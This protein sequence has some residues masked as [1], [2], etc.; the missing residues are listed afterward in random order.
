MGA[1]VSLSLSRDGAHGEGICSSFFSSI[2]DPFPRDHGFYVGSVPFSRE[3][4]YYGAG[5]SLSFPQEGVHGNLAS[6]EA[7]PVAWRGVF[8]SPGGGIGGR[9]V[10]FVLANA[11]LV[12][13]LQH[14][15]LLALGNL[16]VDYSHAKPTAAYGS[17]GQQ[18]TESESGS[19]D[20]LDG[21]Y[22]GL[23][24]G[25]NNIMVP[26]S[27]NPELVTAGYGSRVPDPAGGVGKCNGGG[28]YKA[29]AS[30]TARMDGGAMGLYSDRGYPGK[31][32]RRGLSLEWGS[33]NAYVTP[34]ADA[35]GSAFHG[36]F[37]FWIYRRRRWLKQISHS[38]DIGTG[39]GGS[40]SYAIVGGSG[41]HS[42][43]HGSGDSFHLGIASQS[44]VR[45]D[46]SSAS[47]I[48]TSMWIPFQMGHKFHTVGGDCADSGKRGHGGEDYAARF[49][50]SWFCCAW[51]L[52]EDGQVAY[53]WLTGRSYM[54]LGLLTVG[55][56]MY[57]M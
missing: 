31:I 16:L 1:G 22:G 46:L 29:S 4:V 47:V 27:G 49:F 6:V 19:L 40:I 20:P 35:E 37:W 32:V 30:V 18:V 50:C 53:A 42:H 5:V 38:V 48:N 13:S 14:P 51:L 11:V 21:G 26:A 39:S 25:P 8:C 15:Q 2:S 52:L 24:V 41:N 10:A 45:S 36:W 17:S 57:M 7:V 44:T 28:W 33:D 12:G 54:V 34:V 9:M 55:F 3:Q 23:K 43:G 56:M